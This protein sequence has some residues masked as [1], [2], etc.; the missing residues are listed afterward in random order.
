M[1]LA[2]SLLSSDFCNLGRELA[3]LEEAGVQWAHFDVID[4]N[5]AP[6]ITFGPPIIK[7]LRRKSKLFFDVHLMI[8]APERYLEDF[9]AAGADILVV[10]VEACRHL[11]R[12]LAHIR[13]LG[14]QAGVALNPA[15]PLSAVDHVMDDL[16]M[17]LIMSVNPGFS[18]Q[19]FIPAC[20]D[21]I[22]ALRAKLDGSG[23]GQVKIQVD[24][25]AEPANAG[26]LTRRGADVLVSGSA[27]FN[28]PPYDKRLAEFMAAAC[29]K[30]P[31]VPV[32]KLN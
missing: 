7:A 21:K 25:G 29:E 3:D 23:H 8:E 14:M 26:E 11:Q 27:F 18:G 24:G 5:F 4:G 19:K 32:P 10:H 17:V 13:E 20:M 22:S 6:N 28:H 9:R 2:P 30:M 31:F 15:T 12:A 1:I 16:D